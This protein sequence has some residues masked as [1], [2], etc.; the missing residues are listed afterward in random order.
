MGSTS[1]YVPSTYACTYVD[2]R[3]FGCGVVRGAHYFTCLR[4]RIE[5]SSAG[6]R[7]APCAAA[8]SVRSMQR[9]QLG[10]EIY[11]TAST[12]YCRADIDCVIAAKHRY[13]LSSSCG[14]R[15]R[16]TGY[17]GLNRYDGVNM[18]D[19]T[20]NRRYVHRSIRLRHLPGHGRMAP[21]E[22]SVDRPELRV[23]VR[24]PGHER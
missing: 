2:T 19:K 7:P 5:L 1:R 22:S 12:T 16:R 3:V 4:W 15:R 21:A 13:C 8:P 11:S 6:V 23:H 24:A 20:D 10:L 17:D 9:A 14:Q 18:T